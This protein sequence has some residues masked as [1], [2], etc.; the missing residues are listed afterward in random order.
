MTRSTD[1]QSHLVPTH[2]LDQ[3]RVPELPGHVVHVEDYRTAH[4]LLERP[5][6][7]A[8]LLQGTVCLDPRVPPTVREFWRTCSFS[9]ERLSLPLASVKETLDSIFTRI[10]FP[11]SDQAQGPFLSPL[12][13]KAQ[14]LEEISNMAGWACQFAGTDKAEIMLSTEY[15]ASDWHV[16]T[17][18][19]VAFQAFDGEGPVFTSHRYISSWQIDEM[20]AYEPSLLLEEDAP[21]FRTPAGT[22]LMTRDLKG[23]T[24]PINTLNMIPHMSPIPSTP[25]PY[26]HRLLVA[27]GAYMAK[28]WQA[29][30]D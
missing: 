17:R 5:E 26:P 22:I 21:V 12:A 15:P 19:A 30:L 2:C 14:W 24:D 29:G 3:L 6:I 1:I 8:A 16:D 18:L 4:Q 27:T 28:S 13:A 10:G 20:R 23:R 7:N 25:R 9:P 11:D